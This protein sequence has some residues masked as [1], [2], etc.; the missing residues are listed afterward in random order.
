M[1][2]VVDSSMYE[3]LIRRS[4]SYKIEADCLISICCGILHAWYHMF[5]LWYAS[6]VG[7]YLVYQIMSADFKMRLLRQR[8][9]CVN[10]A[11]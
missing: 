10:A 5:C 3:L 2:T 1:P 7:C 6:M 4:M 8:V 9:F 11:E